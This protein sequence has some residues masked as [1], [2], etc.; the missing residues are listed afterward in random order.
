MLETF[1]NTEWSELFTDQNQHR[2]IQK[3]ESGHVLFFPSLPFALA[4]DEKLFLTETSKIIMM[5]AKST[6]RY[7]MKNAL[8]S[9]F[10]F[11]F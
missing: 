8:R 6:M 11:G 3:L 2:A 4:E 10:N 9:Y 1:P 5:N 7:S